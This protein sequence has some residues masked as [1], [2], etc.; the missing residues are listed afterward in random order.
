MPR[1]RA[2]N[3]PGLYARRGAQRMPNSNRY[4]LCEC[5]CGEP[6]KSARARF[7]YQHHRRLSP[8]EYI[9]EDRGGETPCW[10]WQRALASGYGA[11]W[12]N[13]RRIT[14][15]R[16]IYKRHRGPIPDDY[17]LHHLCVEMGYGTTRCVNPD[18]LKP[19][20]PVE[21]T[22][23]GR[24][25]KFTLQTA[26]KVRRLYSEGQTLTEIAHEIGT[27]LQNVYAIVNN[28]SWRE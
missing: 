16:L 4:S 21:N 11:A 10:I 14:A 9:E 12:D 6:T 2:G 7:L 27:S 3:T 13:G 26:R 17:H 19:V 23:R 28:K 1:C 22:R 5:G 20:P 15:Q 8:V 25:A 18:H 24:R